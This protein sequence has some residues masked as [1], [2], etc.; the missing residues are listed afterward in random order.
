VPRLTVP[1]GCSVAAVLALSGCSAPG[2]S[3]VETAP[4]TVA[5]AGQVCIGVADV[6][7]AVNGIGNGLSIN[8]LRGTE[9]L[10]ETRGQID[11]RIA[12]VQSSIDELR[13]RIAAAPDDPAAQ[14]A[15]ASLDA[16]VA[17]VE[18]A[19]SAASS[20]ARAALDA[21]S[22]PSAVSAAAGALGSVRDALS[23]VGDLIGTATG[24][25]S[26]T[27]AQVRAAFDRAPECQ[28]LG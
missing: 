26:G 25:A 2:S 8:P 14:E 28:D 24:A 5:W 18:T 3:D 6:R 12:E 17:A 7:S 9:G 11:G 19:S 10:A 13:A 15:R 16:A 27:S 20:S 23:A 1:V 21:E 22:I 4:A